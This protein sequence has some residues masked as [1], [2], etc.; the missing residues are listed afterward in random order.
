[1][2]LL[3]P[4]R[5]S[6]LLAPILLLISV[7]AFAGGAEA[8]SDAPASSAAEVTGPY[9]DLSDQKFW[10][11]LGAFLPSFST[12]AALDGENSLVPGTTVDVEDDL[13]LAKSDANFRFD[14][15]W[16]ISGRHALGA[17]YFQFTRSATKQIAADIQYG[18]VKFDASTVLSAE[19]KL[20]YAGLSYRYSFTQ[21]EG[22]DV[23][24]IAGF[25]TLDV[26]AALSGSGTITQ[27]GGTVAAFDGKVDGG[28]TAPVP[29]LGLGLAV[30]LTHRL[31]L[32]EELE[33]FGIR[34]AGIDG[35]LTDNRL[36]L[37]W[38]PFRHVGFG[39]SYNT[40]RL[41]VAEVDG[42]GTDASFNYELRGGRVYLTVTF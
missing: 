30:E 10:I 21:R 29:V 4:T 8:K 16:R 40:I 28:V 13:G 11:S 19:T 26:S 17:R 15:V 36:S 12:T 41:R 2:R 32:R 22:V 9:G 3:P 37:D 1:M 33:F 14:F 25:D 39:L 35:S 23:Y 27:G 18:D 5:Q 20:A 7:P 24:L 6:A 38:H 34:V 31:F 42:E